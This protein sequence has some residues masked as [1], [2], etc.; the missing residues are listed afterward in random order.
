MIQQLNTLKISG[1]LGINVDPTDFF[2]LSGGNALFRSNAGSGNTLKWDYTNGRLGIWNNAPSY[3]LDIGGSARIGTSSYLYWD[4]TNKRLG[5]K[6]A[7]PAHTLDLSG[8]IG[9]LTTVGGTGDTSVTLGNHLVYIANSTDAL[10]LTLPSA[11]GL[12]N[13]LYIVANKGAGVVTINRVGSDT[14]NGGSAGYVL[15]QGAAVMVVCESGSSPGA[16]R[17]LVF[18]TTDASGN[19]IITPATK[20]IT[21]VSASDYTYY[22]PTKGSEKGYTYLCQ[23]YRA[24]NNT[25]YEITM[26]L[27]NPSTASGHKYTFIA[28]FPASKIGNSALEVTTSVWLKSQGNGYTN[29]GEAG[30][31]GDNILN[32]VADGFLGAS[33]NK[34]EMKP[35][36]AGSRYYVEL[37]SNGSMWEYT[38]IMYQ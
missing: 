2:E 34:M 7:S 35:R 20:L 5:I 28:T 1:K 37:L 18:S 32:D 21:P 6:S 13:R 14:I 9:L 24:A 8:T 10:T 12:A 23:P 22:I 25:S 31:A 15:Q 3:P 11:S 26:V 36:L 33:D 27:P 29:T 17:T 4:D 38:N 19:T 16:W 30:T